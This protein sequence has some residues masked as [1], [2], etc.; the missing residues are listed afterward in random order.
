MTINITTDIAVEHDPIA[1][2]IALTAVPSI[3]NIFLFSF[4]VRPTARDIVPVG[5]TGGWRDEIRSRNGKKTQSHE[6]SQFDGANA[7]VR[8]HAVLAAWTCPAQNSGTPSSNSFLNL[9]KAGIPKRPGN[10]A[11]SRTVV[12]K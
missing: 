11:H 2:K 6:K 3:F 9:S 7:A 8:V 12:L 1:V 5:D 10:P 4:L